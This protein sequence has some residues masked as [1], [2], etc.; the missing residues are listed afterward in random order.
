M[1]QCTFWKYLLK[2]RLDRFNV[3]AIT[4]KQNTSTPPLF[5]AAGV[6]YLADSA[7]GR[8]LFREAA[9]FVSGHLFTR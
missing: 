1:F 9:M 4:V 3:S 8:N 2:L 7:A 6:N 5:L